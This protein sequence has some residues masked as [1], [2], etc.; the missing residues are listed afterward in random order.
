MTCRVIQWATGFVG[1]ESIKGILAHPELEL[2]G[3]WVHSPD[4]VGR[5]AGEIC[6]IE[7]TGVIATNS[8][9]ELLALGADAV[10]YS[11]V[12]ADEGEIL[13]FLEAAARRV[14]RARPGRCRRHHLAR[15]RVVLLDR[16]ED[17]GGARDRPAFQLAVI[18]GAFACRVRAA[19]QALRHRRNHDRVVG[20]AGRGGGNG[21]EQVALGLPGG[22][23]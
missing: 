20:G 5:D 12:L 13:Q 17:R 11:P 18:D 16:L 19:L 2:V 6:G 22:G 14:E 7:P 1:Q 21:G 4:K 10:V 3:C 8:I 15:R 9:D 23:G